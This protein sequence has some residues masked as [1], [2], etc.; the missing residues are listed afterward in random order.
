MLPFDARPCLRIRPAARLW[1]RHLWASAM[2]ATVVASS[3]ARADG[4]SPPK[5]TSQIQHVIII[6]QENRSFDSYFGTYPGANGIPVGTCVPLDPSNPQ[7]GCVQ[8]F[9]DPHERNAGGPHNNRSAELD[10]DDGITTAKMDGFVYS[11]TYGGH[12]EIDGCPPGVPGHYCINLIAGVLLHDVMGYHD[13]DEIPNYWAYAQHFVLQDQMYEGVRSWSLAAHLDLTSEWV[14]HCRNQLDVS[15][16][17][18]FNTAPVPG[19]KTTYPWVNLFQLLDL[20]DVTW[21]YYI[22]SGQEPDC[23]DGELDCEPQEQSNKVP[24]FWNPPQSFASVRAQGADYLTE[25]NP[26]IDQFLVDIKNGTLP[27]VSWIVP[28]DTFSEHPPSSITAGME[29][30]TSLVNAV[31]Q[32]PYWQNTAVFITWDD[33]GGF[34]DHV[35]PPIVDYN[36]STHPVQG[37][38]LRVPGLLVSAWAKKGYID[39]AVYS[40]DSYATFI[41]D[42]FAGGARLDPVAM[43]EPDARPDVRDALKTVT[44]M[45]GTTAKIGNLAD[46]FD[47]RGKPQP[48]LILSTHIPVGL[49]VSC[50]RLP[51]TPPGDCTEPRVKVTWASVSGPEVPGPFTYQVFRDGTALPSCLTQTLV[52]IDEPGAGAHLYRVDSIDQNNVTSPLSSAT[53][54][55]VPSQ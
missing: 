9:H 26:P 15:T 13:A 35:V 5:Q 23:E 11:Q 54:A 45:D 33:W 16:C 22:G 36:G 39:H 1:V 27:Q 19:P 2:L 47:F 12:G 3:S 49:N 10:L 29:F 42:L 43:G 8:S 6:M 44:F 7:N 37:F 30:V 28:S 38:G 48:P 25:H 32:S 34:Y 17:K 53:E 40:D 31:A 24:S 18:T 4:I 14:A 51:G 20:H 21:K 55:D 46:E 50:G 52:C 41:E